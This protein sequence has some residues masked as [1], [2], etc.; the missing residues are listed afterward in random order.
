MKL[1]LK[2]NYFM[3]LR[4]YSDRMGRGTNQ[5]HPGQHLPDKNLCEQLIEIIF[6][7]R[8]FVR[9]VCTTKNWWSEMCDVL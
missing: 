4:M 8:I 3:L 1:K 6:V 5:N 9:F 7:Q 2:L